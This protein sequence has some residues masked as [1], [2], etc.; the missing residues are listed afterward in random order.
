MAMTGR[1]FAVLSALLLAF[2]LGADMA[3][4]FERCGDGGIAAGNDFFAGAESG[5]DDDVAV[6]GGA[7]GY[8]PEP[9]RSFGDDKDA[10]A[11]IVVAWQGAGGVVVSGAGVGCA[12]VGEGADGY[13]L[14]GDDKGVG[15]VYGFNFGGGAHAGFE[16][17]VVVENADFDGKVGDFFLTVGFFDDG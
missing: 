13:A 8:L 3:A 14:D 15:Y 11:G 17:A 9:C 6:V 1:V 5:G 2:L 7:G 4:V 10:G 12:G 16:G